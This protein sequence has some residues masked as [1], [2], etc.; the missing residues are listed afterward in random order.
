MRGLMAVLACAALVGLS[1]L[2]CSRY[3]ESE[4]HQG[5]G[6]AMSSPHG[7]SP[8]VEA[9]VPRVKKLIDE[10]VKDPNRAKQVE[11]IL[12]EL[13]AEVKKTNEETR[14]FHEQLNAL[15]SDYDAKREQFEKVVSQ[16]NNTRSERAQKIIDMRFKIRDLLT[17]E[18][19]KDLNEKMLKLRTRHEG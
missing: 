5:H 3:Y 2:G 17:A 8:S 6:R 15:N 14:G 4:G 13:I 10:T 7:S 1:A 16:L 9:V 12:Q 19:W 18:E 11:G